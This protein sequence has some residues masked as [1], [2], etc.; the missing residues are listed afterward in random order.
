VTSPPRRRRWL[1][2][3]TW[4]A[5]GALLATL[6]LR[7]PRAQLLHALATGPAWSVGLC[8]AAVVVSVLLADAAAT[9]T[10]FAVTGLR[11]RWTAVL[12]ARG[13]TYLLGLLNFAVGQGGLGVFLHR[14]GV[15]P[16]RALGMLLFL[17]GTQLAA[18]AAVA[19]AGLAAEVLVDAH[20]G[21][22]GAAGGAGMAGAMG[23]MGTAARPALL[24]LGALG[25]AFAVGLAVLAWKPAW[26]TRHEILAPIFAAGGRGMLRAVAAR[27]PHVLLMNGGLWLALRLWGVALPLAR[28]MVLL[29][30]VVL[31]TVVPIAPSAIGTFEVGVVDMVAPYAPGGPAGPVAAQR[32]G[33]FAFTLVYHA[34]SIATQALVGLACLA[35]LTRRKPALG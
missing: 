17:M 16:R 23:T 19:G 15:P 27:L 10:A 25:T 5:A 4:L 1:P 33:L 29:S 7:L 34:F 6:A 22:G 12:L 14:A 24:V 32:A 35:I 21:H 31:I 28:G 26:L 13:A 3:L 8:S 11:C 30:V 18:L 2:W 20:G 9:V